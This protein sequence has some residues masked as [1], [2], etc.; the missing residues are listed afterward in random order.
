MNSKCS[1]LSAQSNQSVALNEFISRD[2]K[3]FT[4]LKKMKKRFKWTKKMVWTSNKLYHH[5]VRKYYAKVYMHF[6][7]MFVVHRFASWVL[8]ASL[9]LF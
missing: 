1:F 2:N 7:N 3:H 5:L 4:K 6:R 8:L 9:H